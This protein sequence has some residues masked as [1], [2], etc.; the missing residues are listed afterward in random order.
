MKSQIRI[1]NHA[2]CCLIDIEGIIGVPEEWQFDTPDERV[3]TY[4]KFRTLL[5]RIAQIDAPRV[6]VNIR[7]TGG[8]VGDALLIYDAL[9]ALKGHITTRCFGYTASAATIIAQAASEGAREVSPN[10]LY[11]IHNS[12]CA[13]EGNAGELDSKAKLLRQTDARIAAIY[14]RRSGRKEEEFAALM[15]ENHGNGRWLSPREAVD[16]GLADRLADPQSASTTLTRN[17]VRGWERFLSRLGLHTDAKRPLDRN[18]LNA[19]AQT[20]AQQQSDT[21][22]RRAAVQPTTVLPAEDP[23]VSEVAQSSNDKAYAEDARMFRKQ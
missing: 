22:R 6:V 1:S 10:C 14:A 11:L 20:A 7:S 17:L 8:D 19:S 23:S 13:T 3:A 16:C 12:S 4:E 9:A 21:E 2:D 15:N 18:T 5:R